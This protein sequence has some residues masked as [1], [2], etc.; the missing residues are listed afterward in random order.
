V[1]LIGEIRD[2]E[3]AAIAVQASLT[4]HLVLAT[5][6]TNDAASTV[7]R[8]TDLG[9]DPTRLA[10]GLKGIVAQ[11]LIRRICPECRVVANAGVPLRLR[12]AIDHSVMVYTA[13]GCELC[14]MTGYHGRIAIM[15]IAIPSSGNAEL[16]VRSPRSLWESAL[17]HLVAGNTSGDELLRVLDGDSLPGRIHSGNG[18][19]GQS[20]LTE[21]V[22]G[23]VDVYVIR[24]LPEGW[25]VLALQR[26]NDT[27]CPA[28]WESVHGRIEP[29]EK[30]AQAAV[31]EVLEETGLQV[32]RLYNVTVQPFYLHTINTIQLAIV[33]AAFVDEP[34]SVK[35][36]AEHQQFEW[37]SPH[38]ASTRFV[39]PR[40]KEALSHILQLLAEG[41]AGPVEDV[42]RVILTLC[43]RYPVLR[44]VM[45][46]W[47]AAGSRSS[48]LRS[49]PTCVSTV[50]LT[51]SEP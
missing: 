11:R 5:L 9:V 3:T 25:Q 2:A 40:E 21:L 20:F 47:G 22:P 33:F 8:L 35:P 32:S 16:E 28:A 10:A 7:T 14:G 39:W 51:T 49:S 24:P 38:D 48:F 29:G 12:A 45:M 27:R 19:S 18:H 31:R 6:H 30:P 42:L 46:C 13:A 34:A 44:T 15:E 37:L 26:A 36:G 17:V 1:V 41:D 50:R 43:S 4:G 23:V